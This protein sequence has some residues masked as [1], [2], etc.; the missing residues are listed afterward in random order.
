MPTHRPTPLPPTAGRKDD[1]EWVA[2]KA[3]DI[4]TPRLLEPRRR[5]SSTF[6]G[7]PRGDD[8]GVAAVFNCECTSPGVRICFLSVNFFRFSFV[9]LFLVL[10]QGVS[11]KRQFPGWNRVCVHI[12][13]CLYRDVYLG[14]FNLGGAPNTFSHHP[15]GYEGTGVADAA[16]RVEG[17][18]VCCLRYGIRPP[19]P[20]CELEV[21][22]LSKLD[23]PNI[24]KM[25][26]HYPQPGAQAGG[27]TGPSTNVFGQSISS[28][29]S[30]SQ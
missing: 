29:G 1:G 7:F 26:A 19:D 5:V 30:V 16:S 3:F 25:L 11:L 22:L 20:T 17:R 6:I 13:A 18:G 21:T 14:G 23:H 9:N 28:P 24:V 4:S 8:E 12:N 15:Q 2:V 10:F 27:R